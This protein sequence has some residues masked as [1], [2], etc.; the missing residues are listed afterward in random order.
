MPKFKHCRIAGA[1]VCERIFGYSPI[2]GI[3]LISLTSS[4]A[5]GNYLLR[6]LD[7]TKGLGHP[8]AVRNTFV[9]VSMPQMRQ[10]VACTI[11]LKPTLQRCNDITDGLAPPILSLFCQREVDLVRWQIP[12]MAKITVTLQ[13]LQI[14]NCFEWD[15]DKVNA[16]MILTFPRLVMRNN[17]Q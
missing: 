15:P 6:M 14:L 17:L 10:S 8:Q 13:I 12:G 5:E 3:S 11:W 2:P 9:P 1:H 4:H 16:L 7:S